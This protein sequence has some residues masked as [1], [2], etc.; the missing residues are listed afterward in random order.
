MGKLLKIIFILFL[1]T[2][3]MSSQTS[4]RLLDSKEYPIYR[5]FDNIPKI[6]YLDSL[7]VVENKKKIYNSIWGCLS[8]VNSREKDAIFQSYIHLRL[9]DF[10]KKL[11]SENN[12]VILISGSECESYSEEK[13]ING[14]PILIN[15]LCTSSGCISSMAIENAKEKFNNETRS[16]LG[17]E[18]EKKGK[19]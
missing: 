3:T 14:K 16:L 10:S 8:R 9:I 2:A 13:I 12:F 5:S 15:Y 19:P 11:Y 17:W 18:I 7:A 6:E 1:T 4:Q